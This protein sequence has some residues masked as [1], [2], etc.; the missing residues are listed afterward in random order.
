M[1]Y[2]GELPVGATIEVPVK[3]DWQVRFGERIVWR[4]ADKNHEG[5]PEGSVTLITDKIIQLMCVDAKEDSNSNADR[6]NYGNNR[7]NHSNIHQWLNSNAEAGQ[8]YSPQHQYDA[9]PTNANV[10]DNNNEYD[11]WAGFLAMMDGGFTDALMDT[12][13]IVAKATYDGGGGEQCEAKIFLPSA[14]EMGQTVYIA[15]GTKLALFS[16]DA[17]RIAYLT[18]HAFRNSEYKGD[19]LTEANGWYWWLRSP[20]VE[21]NGVNSTYYIG[22]GGALVVNFAYSGKSGIRPLCN[23]P[24]DTRLDLTPD[25]DGAYPLVCKRTNLRVPV[26]GV[27]VEAEPRVMMDGVYVPVTAKTMTDGI[28]RE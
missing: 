7:Y 24:G 1:K 28:W 2:L 16:D 10:L 9:P 25:A 26:G 13:L 15:E 12:T 20:C 22:T 5:Y 19:N 17:S 23:L 4:V 18:S 11:Q 6:R 21:R 3:A 14:T 8:W 27:W